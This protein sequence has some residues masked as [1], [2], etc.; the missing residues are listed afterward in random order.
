MHWYCFVNRFLLWLGLAKDFKG[1]K[2]IYPPGTKCIRC[3]Y[4]RTDWHTW[5]KKMVK[6]Y[7]LAGIDSATPAGFH[8]YVMA[9]DYD[10]L[11]AERFA[12]E[13]ALEEIVRECSSSAERGH[14]DDE[15]GALRIAEEALK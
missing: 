11:Q 13:A 3:G 2:F 12:L 14:M 4:R 1:H 9:E 15:C 10:A 6:R 7:L 8:E 5:D